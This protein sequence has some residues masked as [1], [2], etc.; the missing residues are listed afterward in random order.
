MPSRKAENQV[1]W[2]ILGMKR[3]EM[4]TKKKEGAKMPRVESKAPGTPARIYPMKVAVVKTGPGVTCPIAMASISFR[5]GA[6]CGV[7]ALLLGGVP[8]WSI[9]VLPELIFAL[10]RFTLPFMLGASLLLRD[11]GRFS[12]AL[13]YNLELR[14]SYKANSLSGEIQYGGSRAGGPQ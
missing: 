14:G 2:R 3:L 6:L 13:K 4:A 9:E 12:A 1:E 11:S 5:T 10:D 7:L 8:S